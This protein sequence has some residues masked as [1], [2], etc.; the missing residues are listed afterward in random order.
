MSNITP[1]GVDATTGQSKQLGNLDV[2]S[3]QSGNLSLG[4]PAPN[5]N[6]SSATGI[7]TVKGA[8]PPLIQVANPTIAPNVV[9][10]PDAGSTWLATNYTLVYT[11]A[12]PGGINDLAVGPNSGETTQSPST[13]FTITA[14][15]AFNTSPQ[16]SAIVLPPGATG[17][18]FYEFDPIDGFFLGVTD[19]P[20]NFVVTSFP[21]TLRRGF[22][23]NPSAT[24]TTVVSGFG[25]DSIYNPGIGAAP[26]AWSGNTRLQA[27]ITGAGST[28]IDVVIVDGKTAS[29]TAPGTFSNTE[30]WGFTAK[31]TDNNATALGNAAQ[32]NHY[33]TVAIGTGA[34]ASGPN[35]IAI[36][37]NASSQGISNTTTSITVASDGKPYRKIPLMWWI[38]QVFLPA[39]L[40]L[41]LPL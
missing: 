10:V 5:V 22:P 3:V 33:G 8:T 19:I 36:G 2:L 34:L 20:G 29:V 31:A 11:F 37:L 32:A 1:S 21:A 27:A 24:N 39:D 25:L 13:L 16:V 35:N 17:V 30:R 40:S 15:Q 9:L 28:P 4:G 41:S 23:R 26:V 7:L 6:A 12:G 38:H 14:G 18:L